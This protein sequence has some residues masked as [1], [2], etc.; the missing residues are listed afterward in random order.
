VFSSLSWPREELLEVP[1]ALV[2]AGTK[3]AQHTVAGGWMA[4]G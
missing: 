4:G 1:L 3:V 2:P